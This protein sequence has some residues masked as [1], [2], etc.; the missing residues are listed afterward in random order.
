MQHSNNHKNNSKPHGS[1]NNERRVG[2]EPKLEQAL[3]CQKYSS[4]WS[5]QLEV[6]CDLVTIDQKMVDSHDRGIIFF[7]RG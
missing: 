2:G 4:I 7:S 6:G 5:L 1:E 3:T